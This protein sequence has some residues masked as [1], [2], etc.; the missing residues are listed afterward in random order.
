MKIHFKRL[1]LLTVLLTCLTASSAWAMSSFIPGA[2]SVVVQKVD[3]LT[4]LGDK[5][6]LTAKEW[7]VRELNRSALAPNDF[8]QDGD[9]MKAVRPQWYTPQDAVP[10]YMITG[11][12]GDSQFCIRLPYN[13]NGKLVASP[14]PGIRPYWS[15]DTTF[16][17]YVLPKG[18]AYV[19]SDKGT[20]P[21]VLPDLDRT[22][23]KDGTVWMNW[24]SAFSA[25]GPLPEG[26]GVDDSVQEWGERLKQATMAGKLVCEKIYGHSP[27]RTYLIGQSNG[28]YTVRYALE[29]FGDLYDGGIDWEGMFWHPTSHNALNVFRDYIKY[30]WT[31]Y[32]DKDATPE[33][34]EAAQKALYQ[35]MEPGSE[36]IWPQYYDIYWSSIPYLYG[37][38]IDPDFLPGIRWTEF[39]KNP[40]EWAE[41]DFSKRPAKAKR[42]MDLI[43][44]TGN[45]SKPLI[46]VFGTYD[47]LC[48]VR[49]C[50]L[51]Y[52]ELV[53]KAGHKDIYRLY[54]VERG[55]HLDGWA[56]DPKRD[57][58]GV[59]QPVLP[60][61]HQS[62]DALVNWVENGKE[63]PANKTIPAADGGKVY[64]LI[65]G[66]L[67]DPY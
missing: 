25:F 1:W 35:Y 7:A 50:A 33:Q 37:T 12:F 19:T 38:R 47:S 62:F 52:Q 46:S 23:D 61:V 5:E 31:L 22:L 48:T 21:E 20:T 2:H 67:V 16:S 14:S 32:K 54:L 43:K 8:I 45:I 41:Y 6:R 58:N 11:Y 49:D 18:Y 9:K 36:F 3:N 26:K 51:P 40:L 44:N 60:Y 65:D 27:S 17:D 15:S 42:N 30:G 57:P 29:H 28:G 56:N 34:K 64:D 4:T 24:R 10:G 63:P 55:S 53:E 13:W 39:L 66:K 59:I